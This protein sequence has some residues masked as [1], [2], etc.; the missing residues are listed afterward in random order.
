[1]QRI[2]S[3]KR[4]RRVGFVTIFG[5]VIF[6]FPLLL[7][8]SSLLQ[9]QVK[10]IDKM[11][12]QLKDVNITIGK[13]IENDNT[14]RALGVVDRIRGLK[15]TIAIYNMRYSNDSV[16]AT[17]FV[18]REPDPKADDNL[19]K[20]YYNIDVVADSVHHQMHWFT[21]LVRKDF[22]EVLYYDMKNGKTA[23]INDW[24][25]IWPASEFLKEGDK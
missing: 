3:Q 5:T 6:I 16:Y 22:N 20:N 24:K 4:K 19:V 17:R 8:F 25:K 13:S 12:T 14:K 2:L 1:M 15:R 11:I 9:A 10:P 18:D 23:D 21:F 7:F